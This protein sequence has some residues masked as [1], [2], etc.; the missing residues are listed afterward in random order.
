MPDGIDAV[1][2]HN[3]FLAYDRPKFYCKR[4]SPNFHITPWVVFYT[5]VFFLLY[6]I[7]RLYILIAAEGR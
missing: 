3:R 6:T 4:G 5:I 2:A 1:W 7:N